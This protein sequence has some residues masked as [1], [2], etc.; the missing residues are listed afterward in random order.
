VVG[1][2]ICTIIGTTIWYALGNPFGI[3][4]LYIAICMPALGM[5][6]DHFFIKMKGNPMLSP[7]P[8]AL[9]GGR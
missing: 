5:F 1:G 4:N 6:V 8:A 3:D 9:T 7:P 2:L